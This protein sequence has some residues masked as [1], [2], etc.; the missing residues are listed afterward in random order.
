MTTCDSK[1][2]PTLK[3]IHWVQEVVKATAT[4]VKRTSVEI[5][6]VSLL[7]LGSCTAKIEEK[8]TIFFLVEVFIYS[9]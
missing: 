2:D 7:G 4:P 9:A 3:Q 5:P 1:I 6:K 8:L